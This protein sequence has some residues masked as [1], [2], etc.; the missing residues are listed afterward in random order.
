MDSNVKEPP[1]NSEKAQPTSSSLEVKTHNLFQPCWFAWIIGAGHF[2]TLAARRISKRHPGEKILVVDQ[3]FEKFRELE[4]LPVKTLEEDAQEFLQ[5]NLSVKIQPQESEKVQPI[6]SCTGVATEHLL[7][8]CWFSDAPKW[9]IPAVPIHVAFEWLF[10]T[11]RKDE[12]LEVERL[13]VP[14]EADKQVPNPFRMSRETLYASFADFV[15]PDN[16]SE[17][18]DICT[19][20]K[21]PRKGNLYEVLAKI[22]VSGF[23]PLVLRSHQLAPGVGGYT[24]ESMNKLLHRVLETPG[25]Y[26]I[27]TSCRCHGVID[28]LSWQKKA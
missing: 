26:L 13:N 5:E 17:P 27:A 11:L 7:Q 8:P 14:E 21:E 24:P 2:G 25:K 28:A 10:N 3:D 4:P 20:T 19:K 12:N 15:C 6:F 18:A 1:S 23:T 22:D 9:V 16:C